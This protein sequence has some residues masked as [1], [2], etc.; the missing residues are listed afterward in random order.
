M[1]YAGANKSTAVGGNIILCLPVLIKIPKT[2]CDKRNVSSSFKLL[3]NLWVIISI[4]FFH[5]RQGILRYIISSITTF[6]KENYLPWPYNNQQK[7]MM[8][9]YMK[10]L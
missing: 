1:L 3:A 2:C 4:R 9:I 10:T 6:G 5:F 7:L 8:I